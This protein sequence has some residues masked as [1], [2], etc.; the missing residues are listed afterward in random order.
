[1]DS[2]AR[3]L[4]SVSLDHRTEYT[5]ATFAPGVVQKVEW[6]GCMY[7]IRTCEQLL[8]QASF[9]HSSDFAPGLDLLCYMRL[10]MRSA[11]GPI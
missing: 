9:Y 2:S 10:T 5:I 8:V 3:T 1:M 6:S 4:I 7:D 11:S